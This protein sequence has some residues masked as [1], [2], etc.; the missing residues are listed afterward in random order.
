M[1]LNEKIMNDI[2]KIMENMNNDLE[3][4]ELGR[5]LPWD[6]KRKAPLEVSINA[7]QASYINEEIVNSKYFNSFNYSKLPNEY[8]DIHLTLG[9]T[10]AKKGEG[11]TLVSSNMAVSFALG[12]RRRTVI[13][14]LNYKN[15][16]QHEIFGVD[17]KPGLC[18]A[19]DTG[20]INLTQT[21]I[22]Q[23]FV[24]PT[25]DVDNFELKLDNIMA[26]RQVIQTLE[27][28]FDFVIV[29]MSS[30]L[31]IEDFPVLF[32]NEVDGLLAVL[33]TQQT[34]HAEIEE[35]FNHLNKKQILG[36]I[37]NRYTKNH[38]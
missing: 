32:A 11:K 19:L 35:M 36:F 29:D 26:V 22:D 28:Q 2:N 5:S 8:K 13:I 16:A 4:Q 6:F 24:L 38:N 30:V 25:G 18:K 20:V 27:S 3:I 31:P 37:M 21:K 14:D 7:E 34:R 15:P 17:Q 10:S 33:D 1:E 9:I 23:L 12:Y